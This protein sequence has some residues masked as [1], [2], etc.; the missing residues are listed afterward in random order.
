MEEDSDGVFHYQLYELYEKMGD[1]R[2]AAIA[3]RESERLRKQ[4]E[5]EEE[6][7]IEK[8]LDGPG[9]KSMNGVTH[10]DP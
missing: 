4:E 9:S 6:L 7:K 2:A 3:L 10:P 8:V 1:H 5:Q